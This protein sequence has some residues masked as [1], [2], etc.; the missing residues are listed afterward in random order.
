MLSDRRSFLEKMSH[1]GA[2]SLLP[3]S[4]STAGD[5][6]SPVVEDANHFVA[7]PYL[8]NMGTDEV[9]VMWVTHK[10]CFSWVEYGAGTYTTQRAFAYVNGLV[11]ANNR[12]NKITL[13]ALKPGTEYKYK[14]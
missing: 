4:V 7:G 5:I 6:L 10:N 12:V 3:L 2:L 11:E 13:P 8:Q 14:I 1:I 9:T